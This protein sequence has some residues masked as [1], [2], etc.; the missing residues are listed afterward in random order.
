M[1][2]PTWPNVNYVVVS[3]EDYVAIDTLTAAIDAAVQP[4]IPPEVW[5]TEKPDAEKCMAAVRAMCG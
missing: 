1:P 3:D 2:F 5:Q 4:E